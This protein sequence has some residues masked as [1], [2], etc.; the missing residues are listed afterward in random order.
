MGSGL[1]VLGFGFWVLG[2]GFWVV[3]FGLGFGFG[4][5]DFGLWAL[6]FGFQIQVLG[7]WGPE[8]RGHGVRVSGSTTTDVRSSLRLRPLVCSSTDTTETVAF[9]TPKADATPEMYTAVVASA[10]NSTRLI[11]TLAENVMVE[12]DATQSCAELL[13]GTDWGSSHGHEEQ[14]AAPGKSL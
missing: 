3:G 9:A 14:S 4:A 8:L 10:S 1:W 13:P 5:L 2:F 6:G 11:S 12:T 7:F